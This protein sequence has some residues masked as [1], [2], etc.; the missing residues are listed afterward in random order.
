M[1]DLP[2]ATES[3]SSFTVEMPSLQDKWSVGVIVGP[4]GSGKTTIARQA[5]GDRLVQHWD[6]PS[7]QSIL[8]G[9]PANMGVREITQ[10][11]GSVGF[12]S[13]PAWLRPFHLL[14]NGEQFRVSVARSLAE[15]STCSV[16]GMPEMAVV[17]EFTSVVDRT[18]A[19]IGSSAI[20]RAVRRTGQRFVAVTCHYDVLP[21]LQFPAQQPESSV[22]A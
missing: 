21:W 15:T 17:D 1:F 19:R 14:S 13:P 12:S 2:P 18:V 20:S 16:Q 8:D 11:L 4:S 10:L 7:D 5:F 6:W 9:F 3:R 22:L